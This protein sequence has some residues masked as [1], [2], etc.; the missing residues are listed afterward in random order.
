M[1]T[2]APNPPDVESVKRAKTQLWTLLG[3]YGYQKLLVALREGNIDNKWHIPH[4][5]DKTSVRS[6]GSIIATMIGALDGVALWWD[7]LTPRPLTSEAITEALAARKT[8]E[9]EVIR[10]IR[11]LA[12]PSGE[13]VMTMQLVFR[14]IRPGRTPSNCSDS[15]LLERWI[16]EWLET[17]AAKAAPSVPEP[18]KTMKPVPIDEPIEPT[19]GEVTIGTETFKVVNAGPATTKYLPVVK[20][21][22]S[23]L[24]KEGF[25]LWVQSM[26]T[27]PIEESVSDPMQWHI[28]DWQLKLPRQV[29]WIDPSLSNLKNT[30][31][32]PFYDV[33]IAEEVCRLLNRAKYEGYKGPPVWPMPPGEVAPATSTESSPG[34]QVVS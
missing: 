14:D 29:I 34:E 12:P 9:E 26:H 19:V 13:G 1:T 3:M 18:E 4:P 30:G 33:K 10:T 5:A 6:A 28:A 31:V 11:R 2:F 8:Q 7:L 22:E 27:K 21:E 23:A 24:G 16:L 32:G 20:A 17:P 25:D 15:A